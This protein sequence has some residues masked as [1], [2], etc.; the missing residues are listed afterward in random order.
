MERIEIRLVC[1]QL[2]DEQIV[3]LLQALKA[4][5]Q[6]FVQE[7]GIEDVETVDAVYYEAGSLLV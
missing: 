3:A 7:N 6:K 4:T 2:S 1:D 5:A